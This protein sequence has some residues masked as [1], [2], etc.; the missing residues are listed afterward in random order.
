[1][2]SQG[3]SPIDFLEMGKVFLKFN[4]D[5]QQRVNVNLTKQIKLCIKNGENH[6]EDVNDYYSNFSSFSSLFMNKYL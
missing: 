3:E 6:I 4:V 2:L 5:L 1:M